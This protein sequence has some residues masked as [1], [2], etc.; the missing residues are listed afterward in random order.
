MRY[1]LSQM[2]KLQNIFESNERRIEYIEEGNIY[3]EKRS[4]GLSYI[5]S[6]YK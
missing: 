1:E 5:V 6:E 2:D 3:E 4:K